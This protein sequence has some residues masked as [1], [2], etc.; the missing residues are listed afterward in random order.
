[1]HAWWDG[2]QITVDFPLS[3]RAMTLKERLARDLKAAM[4]SKDLLTRD[5]VRL[6]KSDLEKEEVAKG[7]D[8]SE[9]EGIAVLQRAVKSRRESAEEYEKGGRQESADQERAEI[10]VVERYLPKQWGESETRAEIE[11]IVEGLGDSADLGQ[12]MKALKQHGPLVDMRL[13]S[14]LAREVFANRSGS[15]S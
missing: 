7:R 15:D 2:T 11:R 4:K 1:M 14:G 10:E 6:V 12:V 3:F 5:V 13:A 8:L 9:P